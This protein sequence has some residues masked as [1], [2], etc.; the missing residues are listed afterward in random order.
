METVHFIIRA[1]FVI[2]I[3]LMSITDIK[4]KKVPIY[5][6]VL[7]A[8]LSAIS[9]IASIVYG[10]QQTV[11][12][13]KEGYSYAFSDNTKAIIVTAIL[14]LLPGLILLAIA[15]CTDKVGVADGII[16]CEIG[17][18]ENYLWGVETLCIGSFL[19]CLV[20]IILVCI[21]KVNRNTRMPF[22]PFIFAGYLIGGYII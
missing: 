15:K 7:A 8:V 11:F 12:G 3:L 6:L 13:S 2:V 14:G 4:S 21:R 20:S 17:F 5:L 10:W 19:L 9:V 1:L 16:L 22:V 18:M